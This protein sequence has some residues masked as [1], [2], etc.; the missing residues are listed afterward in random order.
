MTLALLE[1]TTL[2]RLATDV[3]PQGGSGVD[4]AQI[5]G[6]LST[7]RASGSCTV[8]RAMTQHQLEKA[9]K[10]GDRSASR[11]A[12][13][14]RLFRAL[15]QVEKHADEHVRANAPA[16]EVKSALKKRKDDLAGR[17]AVT[18]MTHVAAEHR[19]QGSR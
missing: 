3:V 11:A 6:L 7:A 13:Y 16:G 10:E 1:D 17:L 15:Q 5:S 19:W 4:N 12:F 9:R 2:Y 14:D 8:L 18:L